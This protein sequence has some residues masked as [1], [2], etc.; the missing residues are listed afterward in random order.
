MQYHAKTGVPDGQTPREA[1]RQRA[2]RSARSHSGRVRFAK[3]ALPVI[4]VLALLFM[5]GWM[6]LSRIVP[7]IN[8]D[9]SASSIRDGKLVMANPKLDGYTSGDLPY[10]LQAAR[11]IQE[12]T[13][14]GAVDLEEILAAVPFGEG[15]RAT[16]TA[17]AG[18]YNSE[19]NT[20]TLRESIEVEST[21]GMSA[22]FKSADLDLAAGSLTTEDP[23]RISMPGATIEADRLEVSNNGRRLLFES[24]VKLVVEPAL[25]KPDALPELPDDVRLK[26]GN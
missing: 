6:W 3:F 19:A 24:R 25:F 22:S 8:V 2:Y 5:V 14:E 20:L 13:G 15:D 16:V 18:R 4:G 12:L 17:L 7:D 11:A 23:V 21:N 26:T 9:V 10:S 1:A